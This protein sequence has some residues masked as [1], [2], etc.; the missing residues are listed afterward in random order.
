MYTHK[1]KYHSL[2]KRKEI[3]TYVTVWMD[4][5]DMMLREVTQSQNDSAWFHSEV[6]KLVRFKDRKW[7]GCCPV[8]GEGGVVGYN[9]IGTEFQL[10]EIRVLETD[11]AEICGCN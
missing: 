8:V 1:I 6:L 5:E 4:L 11:I 2:I 3:L 10:Y 7:N 9:L